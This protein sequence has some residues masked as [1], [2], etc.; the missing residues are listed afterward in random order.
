MN[1]R[2]REEGSLLGSSKRLSTSRQD[3]MSLSGAA[4]AAVQESMAAVGTTG[5]SASLPPPST[6]TGDDSIPAAEQ[7]SARALSATGEVHS[8]SFQGKAPLQQQ[9]QQ[10]QVLQ[11]PGPELEADQA[12]Q[13]L[14]AQLDSEVAQQ[15][16]QEQP[17]EQA[18]VRDRVWP[19]PRPTV[20]DDSAGGVGG[21]VTCVEA[22]DAREVTGV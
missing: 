14:L 21:W 9:Q 15:S 6:S 7:L 22:W 11:E 17:V 16:E 12:Q 19:R 1:G 3:S 2:P 20:E 10:Q 4:A 8:S 5:V 13:H 18:P